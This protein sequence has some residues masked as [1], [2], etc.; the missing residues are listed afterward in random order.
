MFFVVYLLKIKK[1]IIVPHTWINDANSV[2]EKFTNLNGVN[3]V[4]EHLCF[5]SNKK[6]AKLIE[7]E[8]EVPNE[9]FVPNFAAARSNCYPC[10]EGTFICLI[11]SFRGEQIKSSRSKSRLPNEKLH[12]FLHFYLQYSF[13]R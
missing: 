3:S 13:L 8:R 6:D 7:N 1:Y 10:E 12:V 11:M 9:R 4:Q 5:W 2:L